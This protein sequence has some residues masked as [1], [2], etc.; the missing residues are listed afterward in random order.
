[1]PSTWAPRSSGSRRAVRAARAGRGRPR[2]RATHVVLPH[3]ELT[4]LKRL[5]ARP[6][7][8]Q[9]LDRLPEVEV[10]SVGARAKETGDRG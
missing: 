5:T 6:L 2:R 8:D 1:M 4:G 9:L 3:E 10:H 7:A